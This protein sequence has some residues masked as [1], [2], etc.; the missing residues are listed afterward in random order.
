MSQLTVKGNIIIKSIVKALDVNR[1]QVAQ[2][3]IL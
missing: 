3:N 1:R 2:V